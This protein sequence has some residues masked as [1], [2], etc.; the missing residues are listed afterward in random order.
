MRSDNSSPVTATTPTKPILPQRGAQ[1]MEE[2]DATSLW[3]LASA[4]VPA[5]F[6]YLDELDLNREIELSS[7]RDLEP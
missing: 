4:K 1:R 6:A 7:P 3:D 5:R 2:L